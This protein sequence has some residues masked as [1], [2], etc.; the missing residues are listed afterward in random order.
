MGDVRA[1]RSFSADPGL[2]MLRAERDQTRLLTSRWHEQK[3]GET[4]TFLLQFGDK[5]RKTRNKSFTKYPTARYTYACHWHCQTREIKNIL[6]HPHLEAETITEQCCKQACKAA[7]LGPIWSYVDRWCSFNPVCDLRILIPSSLHHQP[8]SE[9]A[10]LGGGTE[11][12]HCYFQ[13]LTFI[14]NFI[15]SDSK[16]PKPLRVCYTRTN[17]HLWVTLHIPKIIKILQKIDFHEIIS[18]WRGQG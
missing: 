18:I 16:Q 4:L 13:K 6:Q 7:C 8:H 9:F 17:S 11:M 5:N 15:I 14:S 1:E 3:T 2:V 12:Q 10:F